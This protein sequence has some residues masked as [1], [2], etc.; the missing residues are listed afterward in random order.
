MEATCRTLD[1]ARR[2]GASPD[3]KW[4]WMLDQRNY[5]AANAPRWSVTSRA[6]HIM[7][8]HYPERLHRL[9]IVRPCLRV[10]FVVV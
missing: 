9:Y 7:S 5:S 8:H 6:L 3:G 2:P 4:V 1:R 10:A